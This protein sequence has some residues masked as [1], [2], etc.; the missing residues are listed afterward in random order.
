M[1]IDFRDGVTAD[2]LNPPSSG[3]PYG[4]E[5]NNDTM[6]DYSAVI[7]LTYGRTHLLLDGDAENEAEA[8]MLEHEGD[9]SADVLKCGHHGAG[10]ATSDAWLARV[11]PK[12]AAISCGPHN[13]FGH[14]SPATME[15]LRAHGAK[16]FVTANDGAIVFI[17]D[18][19]TVTAEKTIG[20]AGP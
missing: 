12:F 3:T 4:T 1:R 7:R 6:N 2:V 9:L 20:T 14:P 16:T 11:H 8:D 19:R 18:G 13:R 5:T 10:N 15:R 17:S